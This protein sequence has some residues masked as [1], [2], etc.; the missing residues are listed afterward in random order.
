ML[1]SKISNR[2]LRDQIAQKIREAVLNNSLK[3]GDRLVERKLAAQF[4][5]SLTAVREALITLEVDGFVVKKHNSSTY[6]TDFSQHEL[7]KAFE[8]RRVLEGYALELAIRLATDEQI[9]S[10][11]LAYLDMVN[12]AAKGDLDLF[13]RKD[14]DWHEAVWVLT[15][16][17]FLVAA[18]RRLVL[19][20]FA[21]SA[22]RIHSG[23]PLDL[24]VDAHR[25]Q[26]M[27]D[28]IKSRDIEGCRKALDHIVDEWLS[29]LS[30]WD[31]SR[32]KGG[33]A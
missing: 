25:H 16:N 13:L 6:V 11:E 32:T 23:S 21:F 17:E 8:F 33:H 29:V 27:L 30:E 22:I 31:K 14:Y 1:F 9:K 19:P 12:G 24:L 2:S 20:L 18:L 3:P 7:E 26:T 10:L 28:S 5:A 15:D 4:G